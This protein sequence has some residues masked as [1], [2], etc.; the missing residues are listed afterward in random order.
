MRQI[1]KKP[2]T[3]IDQNYHFYV[4]AKFKNYLWNLTLPRAPNPPRVPPPPETRQ[5]S[6]FLFSSLYTSMVTKNKFFT[7]LARWL[8]WLPV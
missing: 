8:P 5:T 3:K 4:H 6:I 7:F 2:R 1:E